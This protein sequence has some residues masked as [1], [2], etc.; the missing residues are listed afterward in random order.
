MIQRLAKNRIRLRSPR[1]LC[2]WSAQMATT[3][4]MEE[5]FF[6]SDTDGERSVVPC[7]EQRSTNSINVR[8]CKDGLPT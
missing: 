6:T 4:A 1:E 3:G 7:H 5:V 2:F 8:P